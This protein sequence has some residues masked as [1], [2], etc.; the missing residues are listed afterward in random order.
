MR[1]T[2][3]THATRINNLRTGSQPIQGPRYTP[4]PPG[5][6]RDP[7]ALNDETPGPDT[8]DDERYW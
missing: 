2:R 4:T 7:E 1:H 6:V 5:T 3:N 8:T